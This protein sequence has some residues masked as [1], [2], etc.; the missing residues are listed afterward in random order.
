MIVLRT[1]L[2]LFGLTL[3]FA[4]FRLAETLMGAAIQQGDTRATVL[5]FFLG[6]V[7]VLAALLSLR[8][9]VRRAPEQEG[10]E[11]GPAS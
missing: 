8:L 7:L 9:A 3:G 10:A 6:A 11:T 4:A 2:F 1:G 5:V